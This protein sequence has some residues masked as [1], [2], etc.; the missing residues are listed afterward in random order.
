MNNDH[1]FVY[2]SFSFSQ[3]L[4]FFHLIFVLYQSFFSQLDRELLVQIITLIFYL[5]NSVSSIEMTCAQFS[6]AS[7]MQKINKADDKADDVSKICNVYSE[8]F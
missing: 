1:C 5:K 3:S 8:F 2:H 7:K 6:T 4:S